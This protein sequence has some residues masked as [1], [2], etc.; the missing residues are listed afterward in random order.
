MTAPTV[1]MH[2]PPLKRIEFGSQPSRCSLCGVDKT[3][4]KTC[5]KCGQGFEEPEGVKA[6]RELGER[7]EQERI[8]GHV[9]RTARGTNPGRAE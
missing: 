9:T 5:P 3:I 8:W 6:I 1:V 2:R 4:V 7:I